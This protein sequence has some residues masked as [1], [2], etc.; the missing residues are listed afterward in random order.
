MISNYSVRICYINTS[1]TFVVHHVTT[2]HTASRH[3]EIKT[4]ICWYIWL[5]RQ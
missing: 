4:Q 1:F 5:G 2:L 3:F